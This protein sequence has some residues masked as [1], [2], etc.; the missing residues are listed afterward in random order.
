[1]SKVI[2]WRGANVPTC[3]VKSVAP[4]PFTG[5]KV[6]SFDE[7]IEDVLKGRLFVKE[8]G[9]PCVVF[10]TAKKNQKLLFAGFKSSFVGSPIRA[11]GKHMKWALYDESLDDIIAYFDVSNEQHKQRVWNLFEDASAVQDK[12][13]ALS[14]IVRRDGGLTIAV[15]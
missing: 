6:N 14:A 13:D 11:N 5:V 8:Q 10:S 3:P 4:C 15:R 1:M 2:F 7:F 9:F 12:V